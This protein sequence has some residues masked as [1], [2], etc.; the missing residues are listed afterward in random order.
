MRVNGKFLLHISGRNYYKY[1][2]LHNII[3]MRSA[4]IIKTTKSNWIMLMI[5]I[6]TLTLRIARLLTFTDILYYVLMIIS[7]KKKS[8]KLYIIVF[9]SFFF[10]FLSITHIHNNIHIWGFGA[11]CYTINFSMLIVCFVGFKYPI[12]KTF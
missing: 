10:L 4:V 3:L 5:I 1:K 7:G 9:L 12:S 2:V 11:S 8:I 6:I